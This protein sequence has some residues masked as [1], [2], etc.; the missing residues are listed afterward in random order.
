MVVDLGRD[1]DGKRIRKWHSGYP[2]K[3]EAEQ[4]RIEILS[5]LQNGVY[6]APTKFTVAQ[7]LRD[8]LA[9]R[10]GLAETTIEGYERDARRITTRIGHMRLRDV[11]TATLNS[12][13]R[14]LGETLAPATVK[15]THAVVHKALKDAVRQ[16]ILA[17]NPAQHVE[18]PRPDTP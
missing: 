2:T 16:G 14:E 10:T 17:R 6:V 12:L 18:L 3:R 13:Y 1:I 5:R 11:S 8:W 7:W 4:A 9:G 15:N